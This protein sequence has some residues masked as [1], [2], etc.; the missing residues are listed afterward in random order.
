M[1]VGLLHFA[2]G[3]CNEGEAVVDGTLSFSGLPLPYWRWSVAY[4]S[5]AK[6]AV[7]DCCIGKDN[8]TEASQR[9]F[10]MCLS[11]EHLMQIGF[12]S[13]IADRAERMR[14]D[15]ED[16][17]STPALFVENGHAVGSWASDFIASGGFDQED[18]ANEGWQQLDLVHRL[19]SIHLKAV[20]MHRGDNP[21]L[22]PSS[23]SE[24]RGPLLVSLPNSFRAGVAVDLAT[25]HRAKFLH[26]DPGLFPA[27]TDARPALDN[28]RF[29]S[30]K[31]LQQKSGQNRFVRNVSWL[32][33]PELEPP[34]LDNNMI[35]AWVASA[36][37][38]STWFQTWP[39][40][41]TSTTLASSPTE[42]A[43]ASETASPERSSTP[44]AGA[45]VESCASLPSHKASSANPLPSPTAHPP[46]PMCILKVKAPMTKAVPVAAPSKPKQH[47]AFADM[48]LIGTASAPKQRAPFE[49]SN[50]IGPGNFQGQSI[51]AKSPPSTGPKLAVASPPPKARP[52]SAASHEDDVLLLGRSVEATSSSSKKRSRPVPWSSLFGA[53]GP[54][55]YGLTFGVAHIGG[56][57]FTV[58]QNPRLREQIQKQLGATRHI[59]RIMSPEEALEAVLASLGYE[60]EEDAAD[61]DCFVAALDCRD[62]PN[63]PKVDL[64]HLGLHPTILQA[65]A[66]H[67]H[68][69]AFLR[70]ALDHVFAAATKLAEQQP[71]RGGRLYIACYCN[72]GK[73]RSATR[74]P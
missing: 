22:V 27:V 52:K 42:V 32:G 69:P 51:I 72:Q 58:A 25:N 16:G 37:V 9:T 1:D 57:D 6:F 73:H 29:Q 50:Q 44:V 26:M 43:A 12:A 70:Y 41:I 17:I 55:I 60:A 31:A 38:G 11:V 13:L 7:I 24:L 10:L 62:F 59:S 65:Q 18:P 47:A 35:V 14:K 46:A 53:N 63:P 36:T 34:P 66:H 15:V 8:P 74:L 28:L 30:Q 67:G 3:L 56:G 19:A 21:P 54:N 20:V 23:H 71:R 61:E 49:E 68:F 40:N 39:S 45:T 33:Q 2:E 5:V 48:T 64:H 4:N